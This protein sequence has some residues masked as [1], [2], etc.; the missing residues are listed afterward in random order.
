MKAPGHAQAAQS[1]STASVLLHHGIKPSSSLPCHL[2]PF[3][4]QFSPALTSW[5][6]RQPDGGRRTSTSPNER[7]FG[8]SKAGFEAYHTALKYFLEKM[9]PVTSLLIVLALAG[10]T[11]ALSPPWWQAANLIEAGLAADKYA[12]VTTKEVGNK[13]QIKVS[14]A[15][16]CPTLGRR[17]ATANATCIKS[18]P[19]AGLKAASLSTLLAAKVKS[20]NA[21]L[22]GTKLALTV[23]QGGK[24]VA[25]GAVPAKPDAVAAQLNRALLGN[26]YF[27]GI[28]KQAPIPGGPTQPFAVFFPKVA[29]IYMDDISELDGL[30]TL[31]VTQLM[32]EVFD[33][34]AHGVNPSTVRCKTNECIVTA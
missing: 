15:S 17:L 22:S 8:A 10:G 24:V 33:I 5:R 12:T 19:A 3:T 27:K 16:C 18:C 9:K 30:Q 7:P 1:V 32:D 4:S 23:T 6:C 21:D 31:T 29:Q 11:Y 14:V 2:S 25:P 26:T 28:V 20:L 34:A 13:L